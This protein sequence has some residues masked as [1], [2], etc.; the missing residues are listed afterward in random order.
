MCGLVGVFG[1]LTKEDRKQFGALLYM[2]ALRG[3]HSTG[4]V[5]VSLHREQEHY[6]KALTALDFLDSKK[7]SA[8]IDK[9]GCGLLGHNRWATIGAVTSENAHPFQ[10]GPITG[11]HNGTLRRQ[12]LLPDHKLFDV[13]S[14]N[15][16]YSLSEIGVK[17]TIQKLD[18][19]AALVWWNEEEKSLN[20]WRNNERTLYTMLSEDRKTLYWASEAGMLFTV[21]SGD[22]RKDTKKFGKIEAVA[23]NTHFKVLFNQKNGISHTKEVINH[24]PRK[25][26]TYSGYNTGSYQGSSY[27]QK[28]QTQGQASA[29]KKYKTLLIENLKEVEI[30]SG[31][32]TLVEG[33]VV[34][35]V[36]QKVRF[37]I[38]GSSFSIEEL[39]AVNEVFLGEISYL[40]PD[41]SQPIYVS[42]GSV[43]K[44]VTAH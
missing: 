40:P 10:H 19:A 20:F 3:H 24:A 26:V 1:D 33:N 22:R 11:M 16:M 21:G 35:K 34:G 4:V 14:D 2:D 18:G 6:K 43:K 29:Y 31:R 25:S 17:E 9:A 13:D 30:P 39:L 7:G 42:P 15:L 23:T 12:E 44:K 32:S 41:I 27:Q 37:N 36:A 8:I 28:K 38:H 5:N